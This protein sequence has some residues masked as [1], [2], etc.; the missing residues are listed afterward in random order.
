MVCYG[1]RTC[2]DCASLTILTLAVAEKE[3]VRCRVVVTE[4]TSLTYEA[5]TQCCTTIDCRA[6]R[7]D[8]VVADDTVSDIDGCLLAAVQTSVRKE[9]YA[10]D[11]AV[12][13]NA[14]SLDDT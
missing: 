6:T 7:N 12:V 4:R 10:I 3:R 9:V 11:A 14:Y 2:E 8:K 1:V 13:A 5:T